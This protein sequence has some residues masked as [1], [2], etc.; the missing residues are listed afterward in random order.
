MEVL[1]L[2]EKVI[3]RYCTSREK[4]YLEVTQDKVSVL[5]LEI[6]DA[7][8]PVRYSN[9]I[10]DSAMQHF[11]GQKCELSQMVW[12]GFIWIAPVTKCLKILLENLFRPLGAHIILSNMR[13]SKVN[14]HSMGRSRIIS[15]NVFDEFSGGNYQVWKASVI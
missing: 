14:C 6:Q 10:L 12:P 8:L 15:Y 11:Q 2:W 5:L 9:P 1:Y 13:K 3:W 4:S 7:M